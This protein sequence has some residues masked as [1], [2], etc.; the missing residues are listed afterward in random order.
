VRAAEATRTPA[1]RAVEGTRCTWL[2]NVL[3]CVLFRRGGGAGL[4]VYLFGWR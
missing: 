2:I 1:V 3:M 4:A